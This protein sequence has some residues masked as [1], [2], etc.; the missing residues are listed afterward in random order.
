MFVGYPVVV[1][2]MMIPAVSNA[3]F[4]QILVTTLAAVSISVTSATVSVSITTM[5]VA[6]MRM[7]DT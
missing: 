7:G 1:E 2:L 6:A 4:V 3:V 5:T